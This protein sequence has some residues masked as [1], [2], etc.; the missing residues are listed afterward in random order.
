MMCRLRLKRDFLK[1]I[2]RPNAINIVNIVNATI[3]VVALELIEGLFFIC[4]LYKKV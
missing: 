1:G 3:A 4:V 2:L